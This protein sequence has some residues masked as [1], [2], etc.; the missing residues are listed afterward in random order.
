[1]S[2]PVHGWCVRVRGFL[3]LCGRTCQRCRGRPKEKEGALALSKT[4]PS[5][6]SFYLWTHDH[7]NGQGIE[8]SWVSPKE[9]ELRKKTLPLFSYYPETWAPI[10]RKDK[11]P[12]TYGAQSLEIRNI[13]AAVY[14][15]SHIDGGS[16]VFSYC[17]HLCLSSTCV[18]AR[19]MILDQHYTKRRKNICWSK[20]SLIAHACPDSES[21]FWR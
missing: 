7:M 8:W 1:M 17:R 4:E 13:K 6:S 20:S 15:H 12:G 2:G 14:V 10:T 5:F 19:A 3:F 21:E 18:S 16:L 9:K 11:R